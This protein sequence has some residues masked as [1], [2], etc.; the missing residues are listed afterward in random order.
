M[1]QNQRSSFEDEF[2]NRNAVDEDNTTMNSESL[3]DSLDD[4]QSML[5]EA[6]I[7][8]NSEITSFNV[9]EMPSDAMSLSG[10]LQR[11]YYSHEEYNEIIQQ[12][13]SCRELLSESE[14]INVRLTE[15]NNLLKEEIRRLERNQ[16]RAKQLENEV[17]SEYFKNIVLKFLTPPRVFDE[18]AQLLPVLQTIL[19]LDER[20]MEMVRTNI[21]AQSFSTSQGTV[22]NQKGEG[23]SFTGWFGWN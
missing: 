15:Q 18:R 13:N 14:E 1:S 11:I 8:P 12:L 23:S 21:A 17:C 20:E 9:A 4:L 10:G 6:E 22:E 16:H 7:E 2:I 3:A 19:R 5:R